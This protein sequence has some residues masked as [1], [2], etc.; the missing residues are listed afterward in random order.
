MLKRHI[1]LDETLGALDM[2]IE[3]LERTKILSWTLFPTLIFL[4]IVQ[5]ISFILCNGKF[6]PLEKI[7]DIG[8]K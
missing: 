1:P 5:A 2:E 7:L 4:S 8:G 6:H 3:A